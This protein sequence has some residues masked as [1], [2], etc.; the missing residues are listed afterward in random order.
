MDTTQAQMLNACRVA[1]PQRAG[2]QVRGIAPLESNCHDMTVFHLSWDG[3]ATGESLPLIMRRYP[4]PL[5][6]NALAERGKAAREFV[7][8][9]WLARHDFPVPPALST[10]TDESG[11]WLLMQA[12]PATNWWLPLGMVDFNRVLP[13]IVRRHV[14]LLARLHSFDPVE[15]LDL[16]LP[17][18]TALEVLDY[19]IAA[20]EPT[21]EALLLATLRRVAELMQA[22]E[23][24]PARLIN[25]NAE[26]AN[27]LV[28]RSGEV[29][30]WVDWD[31]AALGDPHWDLAALIT[32]LRGAYQ[33]DALATNA[34][35]WYTKETVRSVKYLPVWLALYAALRWAQCV[36]L[37]AETKVGD[38]FTFPSMERFIAAH[39]SHKAWAMET[40]AEVD[41]AEGAS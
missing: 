11:E 3:A 37:K 13:P 29:I 39:D 26:V 28:D 7:V 9:R 19:F 24:R 8:L 41:D 4:C 35:A 1:F 23:E 27:I 36:W 14:S 5:G 20:I 6:Y 25:M 22:V 12:L 10:G 21:G 2:L 18:V 34:I 33:M 38:S 17:T 30:A 15:M 31:N 32:S 16:D 40:L